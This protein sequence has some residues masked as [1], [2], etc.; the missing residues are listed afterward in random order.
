MN[1]TVSQE[2]ELRRGKESSYLDQEKAEN[3]LGFC[4]ENLLE[5]FV[6]KR[7]NS[8]CGKLQMVISVIFQFSLV[9][10]LSRVQLLRPHRLYSLPG[11]SIHGILQARILEWVAISFFRDLPNPGIKPWTPALQ[12]DSVPTELQGKPPHL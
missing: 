9:Q 2:R 7:M 5:K 10:S 3:C 6:G 1:H 12:A 8:S 11:V 4:W